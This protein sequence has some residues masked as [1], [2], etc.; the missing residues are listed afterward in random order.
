MSR[1]VRSARRRPRLTAIVFAVL[2][3]IG[4]ATAGHFYLTH[5]LESARK[6]LKEG[7]A[8]DAQNDLVWCLRVWPRSVPVHVLKARALRM[9]GDLPA[10]EAEL[11]LCLKLQKGASEDIQL[12]FLLMRVQAQQVDEVEPQ[13]MLYVENGHPETP[14]ILE[15]LS[16]AYMH[17]LRWGPALSSLDRWLKEEPGSARARFWRGWVVEQLHD[18]E[19]AIEDYQKAIDLAPDMISARLRLA[20]LYLDMTQPLDAL[21]HL[22]WLRQHYPDRPDVLAA[23]GRCKFM[24]GESHEARPLLEAAAEK[25]PDDLPVLVDLARL[26]LQEDRVPE[27]EKLLRRVLELSPHEVEAEVSLIEALRLQGRQ[28]EAA[29]AQKQ[30]DEDKAL[31]MKAAQLLKDEVAHP[32]AGPQRPYEI[33]MAFLRTGQDRVGREWLYQALD[34]DHSFRPAHQALAE[35]F[36]KKGNKERAA[37]HRRRLAAKP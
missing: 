24:Q 33:G 26:D 34:R 4:T 2:I 23:L 10:A 27:A 19:G 18:R 36:E 22:E 11:N 21:P 28:D 3:L 8:D 6:A 29:E 12:E 1:A 9:K 37:E 35:H 32:S 30:C 15:T 16:R 5:R 17:N 13:L 31:L 14:L 20:D 25:L 7:R